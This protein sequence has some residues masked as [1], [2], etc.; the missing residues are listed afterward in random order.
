MYDFANVLL[1]LSHAALLRL[2]YF[3]GGYFMQGL[4][5]LLGIESSVSV[6]VHPGELVLVEAA[7][8]RVKYGDF[9]FL[10]DSSSDTDDGAVITVQAKY[11]LDESIPEVTVEIT[12]FVKLL[13][14]E[15]YATIVVDD[16]GYHF[17]MADAQLLGLFSARLQFDASYGDLVSAE[18]RVR[19]DL[20]PDF[21]A[22]LN[23][24]V[25]DALRQAAKIANDSI[26]AAVAAVDDAQVIVDDLQGQLDVHDAAEAK[27][28]ID[29]VNAE[30][31]FNSAQS[32]YASLGTAETNTRAA[33][34]ELGVR[35]GKFG[36]VAE[37]P[38]PAGL[39]PS[40]HDSYAV[41]LDAYAVANKV[42]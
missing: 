29:L 13:G 20:G 19:G 16:T 32:F 7:I 30:R 31:K 37:I 33:F 35:T 38:D 27:R 9:F 23:T 10:Q 12:G 15:R 24:R 6:Q 21:L 28:I 11:G 22:A 1:L 36:S 5:V 18:F 40:S 3:I 39:I 26:Q 14:I 4:L 17:S 34:T 42:R 25:Q 41:A 2:V 8:K